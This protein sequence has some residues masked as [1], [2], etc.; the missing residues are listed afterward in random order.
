MESGDFALLLALLLP[1]CVTLSTRLTSLSLRF[2]TCKKGQKEDLPRGNTR[3]RCNNSSHA[4]STVSGI[5]L[6]P[7][8]C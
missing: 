2:I 7:H 4:L 5:Q 6:V 1:G 8:T 3:I